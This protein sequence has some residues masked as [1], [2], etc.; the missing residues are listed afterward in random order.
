MKAY[1]GVT[2]VG[3][4]SGATIRNGS[5]KTTGHR[6]NMICGC[7]H[8][9]PS[10]HRQ[11]YRRTLTTVAARRSDGALARASCPERR[12]VPSFCVMKLW[13]LEGMTQVDAPETPPRASVEAMLVRVEAA[14]AEEKNEATR[15]S[16]PKFGWQACKCLLT[17]RC[18]CHQLRHR[19]IG[20]YELPQ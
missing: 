5:N 15:A 4:I 8:G 20:G 13:L 10:Q 19:P 6:P 11:T 12:L 3:A 9:R 1:V 17:Q 18:C 14:K 7:R 2:K 16:S